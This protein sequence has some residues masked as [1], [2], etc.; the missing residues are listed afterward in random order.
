MDTQGFLDTWKGLIATADPNTGMFLH[1]SKGWERVLG[2]TREELL[3]KPFVEFV[4]PDDRAATLEAT[5]T[6]AQGSD[7]THFVNRYACKDGSYKWIA[8][9]SSVDPDTDPSA[10][11]VY[12]SAHDITE[13]YEAQHKL[14][15]ALAELKGLRDLMEA[16]TDLVGLATPDKRV[17]YM[18]RAGR[19]M[20]GWDEDEDIANAPVTNLHPPGYMRRLAE[21]GIPH[22]LERGVWSSEGELLH[23]DG[24]VLPIS[25]VVVGLRDASGG[26]RGV[27]TIIRDISG[28][29]QLEAELRE[30]TQRL[31]DALQAMATPFIPITR[32]I[33][34]MPL[35]G[36]MDGERAEQI[37]QVALDGVQSSGARVVIL[38]ITGLTSADTMVAGSLIRTARALRLI[39]AQ[40]I[41]TGIQ[42][43]VAQTLV[44]LGLDLGDTTIHA[45]LQIAIASAL[46][47]S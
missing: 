27:G 8:W 7:L 17:L 23:R 28:A 38:D 21:E 11:L 1:L 18:N 31:S 47:A 46:A 39:G 29:K 10:R 45:T 5:Q 3:A 32:E 26:V 15:E 6:L 9:I 36:Q 41:L 25:Q 12:A 33:V 44:G 13:Q 40:T 42:P 24:T 19:R 34:V 22:A 20:L 14:E 2:W 35:I 4:H 43:A 16:T 30:R 37:M